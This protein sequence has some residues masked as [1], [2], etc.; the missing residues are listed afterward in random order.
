MVIQGLDW[1]GPSALDAWETIN[2]LSSILRN[3]NE[4]KKWSFKPDSGVV[5][6][7]HSNG[8][9]GAVYLAS[10]YPDKILGGICL[11]RNLSFRLY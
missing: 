6:I 3:N 11:L 7:G 4:W 10:R 8:G 5:I 2:A 9:Q 1:H